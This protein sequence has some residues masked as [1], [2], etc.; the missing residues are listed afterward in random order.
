MQARAEH[1]VQVLLLGTVVLALPC[2]LH[3]QDVAI[4]LETLLRARNHDRGMVDAEKSSILALPS[5]IS[6]SWR[7]IN[8]FQIVPVRITEIKRADAG[9]CLVPVGYALRPC[10][11]VLHPVRAQ[12]RV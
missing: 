4:K 11:S 9:G 10:R 7:E 5:G 8:D 1:V 12:M 2:R 6:L 3:A